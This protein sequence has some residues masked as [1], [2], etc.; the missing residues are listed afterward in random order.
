M[1]WWKSLASPQSTEE[2][3]SDSFASAFIAVWTRGFLEVL[4][5]P[6]DISY[7][8]RRF[9]YW[10]IYIFLFY[11]CECWSSSILCRVQCLWRPEEGGI[12]PGTGVTGN[13]AVVSC[14][15][16]AGNQTI[17]LLKRSQCFC[18]NEIF[19]LA[20]HVKDTGTWYLIYIFVC[21]WR[22]GSFA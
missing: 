6:Y 1:Y 5:L 2:V 14:Q 9:R 19:I 13:L 3:Y 20:S 4:C 15:V 8:L 21:S 10:L 11:D 22:K 18:V 17:I 12:S 16:V 7:A